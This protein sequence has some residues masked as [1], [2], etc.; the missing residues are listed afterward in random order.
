MSDR[1]RGITIEINGN[2][3]KLQDSLKNVN[4]TLKTTT[5]DL[6]DINKLLKLD[7]TNTELLKQKQQALAAAI[8]AT[9]EK[10]LQEKRALELMKESNATGKVTEEQKA[11]ERE[12]IDNQQSLKKLEDGELFFYV[13]DRTFNRRDELGTIAGS[14]ASVRDKLQDVIKTTKELSGDVTKSGESLAS[15]A[16]AASHVA[17]QVT[18]AVED[19]SR[20][21]A[22][23]AESVEN[24]VNNTN[25]MGD[26]YSRTN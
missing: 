6:K 26:R 9:E 12:I 21:A 16:E 25:E 23:Q 7:P 14:A 1:I 11:L 22:S 5:S 20:G 15:S 2:T 19:I 18:C 4:T 10:I 8:K 13:D 24:S 17:E 3:T